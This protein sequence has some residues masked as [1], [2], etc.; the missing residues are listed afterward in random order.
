MSI[1]IVSWALEYQDLP[2]DKRTGEPDSG[3]AFVLVALANHADR[4]GCNSFPS[5]DTIRWYT[6][7]SE[8]TIQYKLRALEEHGVIAR[9][10]NPLIES[11]T[12]RDPRKW[13]VSY[14]L[15]AYTRGAKSEVWGA[16]SGV[17]SLP[18]GAKSKINS[19]DQ[20]CKLDADFAPEPSLN[21]EE[22]EEPKSKDMV[23][24]D[25]S[26]D[27]EDQ[28]VDLFGQPAPSS[29]RGSSHLQ[30]RSKD[31]KDGLWQEFWEAY[32]LKKAKIKAR[33]AWSKAIKANDP[34]ELINAAAR[35]AQQQA[36]P[37]RRQ[38]T[39]HPATWLNGGCWDDEPE[40]PS[41]RVHRN[42]HV[43]YRDPDESEYAGGIR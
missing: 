36:D 15:V 11:V 22:Q 16:K 43:P 7:L 37:Q 27:H 29:E 20:G 14:D 6:K 25:A 13:P 41:S 32:P 2:L 30:P 38:Y 19:P 34:R 3:C 39:K 26:T 40:Q 12:I 24:A 23:T 28:R 1:Q 8:R 42:G 35:Y 5:I 18:R 21:L 33:E 10:A 17:Q 31:T 9:T 4:D